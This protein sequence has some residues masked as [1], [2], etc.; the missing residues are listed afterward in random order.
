MSS[1]T[2]ARSIDGLERGR[3]NSKEFCINTYIESIEGENEFKFGVLEYPLS[4]I[5]S[6]K[7]EL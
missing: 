1:L 3:E 2:K 6:I 7:E 5:Q 4:I